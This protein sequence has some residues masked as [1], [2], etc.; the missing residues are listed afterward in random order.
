MLA[1]ARPGSSCYA[2]RRPHAPR[3]LACMLLPSLSPWHVASACIP[4]GK[5][6][7]WR[8]WRD[9]SRNRR[10]VSRAARRESGAQLSVA[11]DAGSVRGRGRAIRRHRAALRHDHGHGRRALRGTSA[12]TETVERVAAFVPPVLGTLSV[13]LLW[14]LGRRLFDWRAGL[15]AAALLAVL[16]GHFMD[17]TM[18]GFVDHHALEA[19]LALATLL[20]IVWGWK[21][22]PSPQVCRPGSRWVLYLWLE[23]RRLPIGDCGNVAAARGSALSIGRR[24]D[25]RRTLRRRWGGRRAGTRHRVSGSANASLS[26]ARWWACWAWQQ[27]R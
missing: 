1:Q 7:F 13:I 12:D 11:S 15:I 2:P 4:R 20:A 14:A 9:V 23:Q 16:P 26:A 22:R 17:R 6:G 25:A 19:F 24:D 27:W 21:H 10:L 3:M 18:L 5:D 8:H